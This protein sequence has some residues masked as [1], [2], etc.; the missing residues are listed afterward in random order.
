MSKRLWFYAWH[1][2]STGERCGWVHP[3]TT[4]AKKWL[5]ETYWR[6]LKY[7]QIDQYFKSLRSGSQRAI[8]SNYW[9]RDRAVRA[10]VELRK[11]VLEYVPLDA[12]GRPLDREKRRKARKAKE[13]NAGQD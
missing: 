9:V 10:D 7:P 5:D 1:F 3:S 11:G 4:A 2:K 8:G 13:E 6:P 12:S